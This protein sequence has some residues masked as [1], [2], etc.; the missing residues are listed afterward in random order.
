MGV[1]SFKELEKLLPSV[2]SINGMQVKDYLQALVDENQIR[3]EKI[4]SGNWYWSFMS[5]AKKSKENTIASLTSEEMKLK[6]VIEELERQIAEEMTK[7]AEDDEMLEDNGMDRMALLEAHEVLLKEIEELDKELTSYSDNDPTEVL[8]KLEDIERLKDTAIK[9]TDNIEAVQSFLLSL[10][11][12][13]DVAGIMRKA[14]GD[15]Y[16]LGEGLREL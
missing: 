11:D 14:C 6:M 13:D 1:Y 10:T 9:W 16:V 8:R 12:R 5:D 7:R 15:E 3:V 2:G 4:G